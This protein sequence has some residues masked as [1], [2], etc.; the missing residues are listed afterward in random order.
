MQCSP[1][2][3]FRCAK[4]LAE[5]FK[6]LGQSPRELWII[7]LL[8]F[9]ES[10]SYFITSLNF[11]LYLSREFG[12]ND[13]TAG[14]YYGLWGVLISVYGLVTGILI[15]KLGVKW[16]LVIGG[17]ISTLGRVLFAIA[18]SR[19][20]LLMS[21]FV[22]MP[23]GSSM[24][25]P[26]LSIGIKRIAVAED[27]S[28]AFGLYYSIMNVSA[29]ISG[30]LTD[31][32]NRLVHT[33]DAQS[34]PQ[35]PSAVA[36]A[37]AG[38]AAII[39]TPLRFTFL[40]GAGSTIVY[41]LVAAFFFRAIDVSPDGQVQKSEQPHLGA[42]QNVCNT[43]RD[44]IF[45]RLVLFATLL[46][47]VNMVFRSMDSVL[48]KYLLRAVDPNAPYGTIYAINPVLIIFLA[49]LFQA[50]FA[51]LDPYRCILVGSTISA[52]SVFLLVLGPHYWNAILFAIVL[53]F[54]E[55]TY[56]PRVYD[57]TLALS[58]HGQEGLYGT[59]SS[60]PMFLTKMLVGVL[61]GG[62]LEE[63]C[64]AQPPRQCWRMWLYI[65]LV[66]ISSPLLLLLLRR[67]IH[68]TEV[69]QR[70]RLAERGSQIELALQDAIIADGNEDG[71]EGKVEKGE[72]AR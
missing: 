30:G 37:A 20:M 13:L 31:F 56:S 58:P 14:T 68:T 25:I 15:D 6:R 35:P 71:S 12:Y 49:P 63:Y 16:S 55:A 22:L 57:Y 27:R 21:V 72:K 24:A 28:T 32:L 69:K 43:V 1:T 53:S 39:I 65:G 29:M 3:C 51:E 50:L 5:K 36:A 23:L 18:P 70:I 40:V 2:A 52:S 59:L 9:L 60:A 4:G 11:T 8:K 45:W 66:S 41:T 26:V 34:P 62:L 17:I 64:P 47:G 42:W 7:F 33:D 10:F 19:P 38:S 44:K 46:T 67:Y 54:G 48:P 61:S